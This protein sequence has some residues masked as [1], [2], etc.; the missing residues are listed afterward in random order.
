MEYIKANSGRHKELDVSVSSVGAMMH[1]C[2]DNVHGAHVLYP[3]FVTDK[4]KQ[5][6]GNPFCFPF[7]GSTPPVYAGINQHGWFR[8]LIVPTTVCENDTIISLGEHDIGGI[9]AGQ[10]IFSAIHTVYQRSIVS[11][12]VMWYD[13]EKKCDTKHQPFILP[14]FHPYF[15]NDGKTEVY[16]KKRGTYYI[17][18]NFTDKAQCIENVLMI[19]DEIIVNTGKLKIAITLEGFDGNTC[20]YLW[21]DDPQKYF[22]VEPVYCPKE[23][24]LCGKHLHIESGRQ[25]EFSM[26]LSIID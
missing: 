26:R 16:I 21:S 15:P 24:F 11:R 13:S 2:F 18:Q 22:C 5:R 4:G 17:Y 7:F 6:G 1:R 12:F 25:Y 9:Y 10:C 8:D 3:F 14:A 23:D 19:G 20:V